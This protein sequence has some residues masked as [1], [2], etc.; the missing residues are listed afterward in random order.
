MLGT[1]DIKKIYRLRKDIL[2]F[3]VAAAPDS[4]AAG[5]AAAVKVGEVVRRE[6]PP[7]LGE[8]R[9]VHGKDYRGRAASKE[10]KTKVPACCREDTGVF[11]KAGTYKA[12][13]RQALQEKYR[14]YRDREKE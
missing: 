4:A 7:V 8:G 2:R 1:S 6:R 13:C 12:A 10:K 11:G 5:T 9:S 14:G 3:A